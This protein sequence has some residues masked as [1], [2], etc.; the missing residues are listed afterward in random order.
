M[1]LENEDDHI[2]IDY[3][4]RFWEDNETL[5]LNNRIGKFHEFI[6][7]EISGY[8][9]ALDPKFLLDNIF[10]NNNTKIN[11]KI[12]LEHINQLLYTSLK[13][14]QIRITILNILE[15]FQ[16]LMDDFTF[17]NFDKELDF[18]EETKF[19]KF[20][21]DID[22]EDIESK[23]K[24]FKY[25]NGLK[26]N[27]KS[28][29]KQVLNKDNPHEE[30]YIKVGKEYF[31]IH[32]TYSKES[33]NK[34][35]NHEN[36]NNNINKNNKSNSKQ[37]V[38]KGN[39]EI[40]YNKAEDIFSNSTVNK[41]D[42]K[43]LKRL[44]D[45]DINNITVK[46]KNNLTQKINEIAND[47]KKKAFCKKEFLLE[48]KYK[49]H[50]NLYQ[51]YYLLINNRIFYN[52]FLNKK[53]NHRVVNDIIIPEVPRKKNIDVSF[54]ICMLLIF[55][56]IPETKKIDLL[57]DILKNRLNLIQ[58]D[59]KESANIIIKMNNEVVLE[60]IKAKFYHELNSEYREKVYRSLKYDFSDK[61]FE[62][63]NF[64][65]IA[66]EYTNINQRNRTNLNT[67]NDKNLHFFFYF[68][69][70]KLESKF[71]FDFFTN[72]K[73]I[74]YS[75]HT[76]NLE[77][78]FKNY[79]FRKQEK[80]KLA[81]TNDSYMH[82]F[83]RNYI[84][85]SLYLSDFIF[86]D[87]LYKK[88]KSQKIQFSRQRQSL[89]AKNMSKQDLKDVVFLENDTN[90]VRNE[91]PVFD[92]EFKQI[93]T[94]YE[95]LEKDCII[96]KKLLFFASET[97]DILNDFSSYICYNSIFQSIDKNGAVNKNDF[98]SNFKIENKDQNKHN[99]Y[100][101][102]FDY[103]FSRNFTKE[104]RNF[105]IFS[106]DSIRKNFINYLKDN[107]KL[108]LFFDQL[109]K[110]Y[111]YYE[112][113]KRGLP[114]KRNLIDKNSIIK[115]NAINDYVHYKGIFSQKRIYIKY[116]NFQNLQ[117]IE[118]DLENKQ[119]DVEE[120][121]DKDL[122]DIN[123]NK[124]SI[125]K[126]IYK[127]MLGENTLNE[128]DNDLNS[129]IY[130][131]PQNQINSLLNKNPPL[132]QNIPQT[133]NI[134]LEI[135][136]EKEKNELKTDNKKDE[137][138]LKN[139]EISMGES[140]M[141]NSIVFKMKEEEKYS[142]KTNKLIEKANNVN[143]SDYNNEDSI[144]AVKEVQ[145]LLK[146]SFDSQEKE[147]EYANINDRSKLNN[148]DITYSKTSKKFNKEI[149]ISSNLESNQIKEKAN[150]ISKTSNR[151][152]NDLINNKE[153]KES[154]IIIADAYLESNEKNQKRNDKILS[155][156]NRILKRNSTINN[157]SP[158]KITFDKNLIEINTEKFNDYYDNN[159]NIN[160][161]LNKKI[162]EKRNKSKKKTNELINDIEDQKIK[163]VDNNNNINIKDFNPKTSNDDEYNKFFRIDTDKLEC[164]SNN[165]INNLDKQSELNS[166][167]FILKPL[168][169]KLS[170]ETDFVKVL[171]IDE[172][173]VIP[174]EEDLIDC[175]LNEEN[176]FFF[177][178]TED[179]RIDKNL[180]ISNISN[181][182]KNIPNETNDVI[183]LNNSIN[184]KNIHLKTKGN[185]NY[186]S[187]E[188]KNLEKHFNKI[189]LS[190]IS[191]VRAYENNNVK[192]IDGEQLKEKFESFIQRYFSDYITFSSQSDCEKC[193]SELINISH[194]IKFD[195]LK[196]NPK[197]LS[198]DKK[199]REISKLITGFSIQTIDKL[200][201]HNYFEENILNL[202]LLILEKYNISLFNKNE[203][204][205]IF[206][207]FRTDF[208]RSLQECL[209]DEDYNK[210]YLSYSK[211]L[212][213]ANNQFILE[214]E[215]K[216]NNK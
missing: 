183:L 190:K 130:K 94:I 196:F 57:Y 143:L 87:L 160:A 148:I 138:Y 27:Q 35:F 213:P 53:I 202:Y 97:K 91:N 1:S 52:L 184:S 207:L 48:E 112:N 157:I 58:N 162:E 8:F 105:N 3:A 194:G 152:N 187:N 203:T 19:P 40:N 16:T 141:Y 150:D 127:N 83:M 38:I 135:L 65:E 99:Y 84:L 2:I 172:L 211:I 92:I 30:I 68:K 125:L 51:N 20:F 76:L 110:F 73:Q 56:N 170:T 198:K 205:K 126:K 163:N 121:L 174:R 144:S 22:N 32:Q 131:H 178:E 189:E 124:N 33:N 111:N 186:N 107:E 146:E 201:T 75:Y 158:K 29:E 132:S 7:G 140:E 179:N 39:E 161:I 168:T 102:I 208:F 34:N 181:S 106:C 215:S 209:N 5:L 151:I 212:F 159:L 79:L 104:V 173:S 204:K 55:C 11:R 192:Y 193:L 90:I 24:T 49:N 195:N 37:P 64:N 80:D 185:N 70:P 41:H 167:R 23:N 116:Q 139:I 154:Q 98:K 191:K 9:S 133:P 142:P 147:I 117:E 54:F 109:P 137:F 89:L 61:K 13:N 216:K 25:T 36:K 71:K 176:S 17:L 12:S 118:K 206:I 69:K 108:L 72:N 155:A 123:T 42:A 200:L 21:E 50:Q 182:I 134:K 175:Y 78:Y 103:E 63:L 120:K 18:Q 66:K 47:I 88:K 136:S 95:Y 77:Y 210:V 119:K 165:Q 43:N 115:I 45:N 169:K 171:N 129:K 93:K 44:N 85:I 113:L 60:N 180:Y 100:S 101:E 62:S 177:N 26:V 114:K 128:S 6:D 31:D 10:P 197:E 86:T 166:E 59:D 145:K 149:S 67:K 188:D 28:P 164:K 214:A 82:K 153:E 96:Y 4:E 14:E 15:Y 81:I 122:E 46:N 74:N 156:A 199:I